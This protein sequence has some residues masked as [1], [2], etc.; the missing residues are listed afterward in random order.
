MWLMLI[1]LLCESP[2]VA[3]D[4]RRDDRGFEWSGLDDGVEL[5]I[6]ER[7]RRAIIPRKRCV[8]IVYTDSSGTSVRVEGQVASMDDSTITLS[9]LAGIP[10]SQITRILVGKS[11]KDLGR[12]RERFFEDSGEV[13]GRSPARRYVQVGFGGLV[14][15]RETDFATVHVLAGW[16]LVRRGNVGLLGE[17]G[18]AIPVTSSERP[19]GTATISAVVHAK[20]RPTSFDPYLTVGGTYAFRKGGSSAPNVGFGVTASTGKGADLR[21]EIRDYIRWGYHLVEFRV[22]ITF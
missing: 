7:A 9:S 10:I 15:D 21:L 2:N 4:D 16:E 5:Y 22:G 20:A 18:L 8:E 6:G 11:S 12:A 1:I 17:S 14:E 19:V 3:A 13:S